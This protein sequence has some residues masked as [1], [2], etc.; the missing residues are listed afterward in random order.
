[1]R[2]VEQEQD[3]LRLGMLAEMMEAE[4]DEVVGPKH[5]KL[6]DR[7]RRRFGSVAQPG[8]SYSARGAEG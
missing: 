8:V 2:T 6:A 7:T 5:A 4:V 3:T 1:M